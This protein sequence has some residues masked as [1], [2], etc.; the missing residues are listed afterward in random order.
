MPNLAAIARAMTEAAEAAKAVKPVIQA[1]KP[2]AQAAKSVVKP[3]GSLNLRP[4]VTAG[5]LK[6]P[7]KQK[8]GDFIKQIHGMQGLTKEG[9]QSALAQLKAMDPNTVVTK[10][11]VEEAFVPSQY[12][13]TDL[14][15]AAKSDDYHLLNIAE[16]NVHSR[17]DFW[18]TFG[19][20]M[21]VGDSDRVAHQLEDLYRA[22]SR[23]QSGSGAINR[24]DPEVRH[25]LELAGVVDK[26]G[27]LNHIQFL[28]FRDEH[29][30]SL[31]DEEYQYLRDMAAEQGHPGEY[32]YR[33]YQRLSTDPHAEGYVE[34]GI[35]HPDAPYEYNHYPESKDVLVSHFRGTS[36]APAAHLPTNSPSAH[37]LDP[38]SFLI[39]E[40]QSDVQKGR[41]QEGPLHQ[42]HATAFK[43]AV[44]HALE[45]G[46]DTVYLPTAETIGFGR[47]SSADPYVSIYDREV[48]EHG[49]NPLSKIPGVTIEQ[50]L[51]DEV[52]AYH[53]IKIAPE[54]KEEILQGGGQRLPGFAKGGSAHSSDDKRNHY[55]G[56]AGG[57]QKPFPFSVGEAARDIGESI[58]TPMKALFDMG[59]S[60]LRG[61]TKAT[62]GAPVDILNMLNVKGMGSKDIPYGMEYWD[63]VL[64]EALPGQKRSPYESI[65]EFIPLPSQVAGA[66][67]R[68]IKAIPGALKHGAQE[69]AHATAAG[70][71]RVIKHKGAQTVGNKI[72]SELDNSVLRTVSGHTPESRLQQLDESFD[73]LSKAD[74]GV[75][76]PEYLA[77]LEELRNIA[78]QTQALNK[79]AEGPLRKYMMRD[80]GTADDPVRKLADQGITH[81]EISE[82]FGTPSAYLKMQRRKAGFPEEGM[83]TTPE[84]R[85]YETMADYAVGDPMPA[86]N[87]FTE[88]AL[89]PYETP[90]WYHKLEPGTLIH[91]PEMGGMDFQRVVDT[92]EEDL[93][94]GRIRPEQ[95][96]KVSMEQAVRRTHEARLEKEA[97]RER[98]AVEQTKKHL[99][100]HRE[101]KSGYKWVELKAKPAETPEDLTPK[102]FERYKQYVNSGATPEQA[103]HRANQQHHIEEI[104]Q[105]ALTNE[106]EAM[107]HCVGG[108]CP[109]VMTND[110][111]VYS[112]RDPKGK[113][114]V[115]VEVAK[116]EVDNPELVKWAKDMTP[117]EFERAAKDLNT[118][119]KTAH[120]QAIES[121]WGRH[122]SAGFWVNQDSLGPR[123]MQIKG[124]NNL[125]PI[126]DYQPYVADFVRSGQWAPTV[127]DFDYT[128]LVKVGNNYIRKG[129]LSQLATE[130]NYAFD[131]KN[132]QE[133]ADWWNRMSRS[134]DEFDYPES[135]LN[136]LDAIKNYKPPEMATGGAVDTNALRAHYFGN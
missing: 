116:P 9:K 15:N 104:T 120:Q 19:N 93:A 37:K 51:A 11:A 85:R 5:H 91:Q 8:A 66:P 43:A 89:F 113:A 123:I 75:V 68:A 7:E 10:Q 29:M 106:G 24:L 79:W 25:K 4:S 32:Q 96:S 3:L 88:E 22:Y 47:G 90:D 72:E 62:L 82:A 48:V 86:G 63:K 132:I 33:R 58:T 111:K 35:S 2:A 134:R 118:P 119:Y 27:N 45:Q 129:E 60:A 109:D 77:R 78:K 41:K 52:P 99:P 42:A 69:F 17:G 73:I 114:H 94:A 1:A 6:G 67:L 112:L 101:Y 125:A 39:E 115:T 61:S 127:R 103:L 59:A 53:K 18:N 74:P 80:M 87:D 46:H 133:H 40:L 76:T 36:N 54:A 95:L 92:L 26:H 65:G 130:Q 128:D 124:K 50:I 70:A 38:N 28:A 64:P 83:A 49:L 13:L 56:R 135:D 108:Y 131:P 12:S 14:K 84:G 122:P 107:N 126:E 30:S 23:N 81:T 97:A 16:D 102:A 55:F 117:E 44:Q 98:E 20:Y 57:K 21:D 34:K 136:M 105:K 110:V 121:G 31:I 100:T 71:P